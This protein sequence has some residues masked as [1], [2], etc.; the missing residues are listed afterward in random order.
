MGWIHLV[1]DKVKWCAVANMIMKARLNM[2]K[3]PDLRS[4]YP[5]KKDRASW[6]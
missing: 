3:L 5:L 1:K 4:C 2:R 6:R